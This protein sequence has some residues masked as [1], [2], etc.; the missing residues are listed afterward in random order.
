M[1]KIDIIKQLI[2]LSGDKIFSCVFIKKDNTERMMVCRRKVT[3]GVKKIIKNRSEEDLFYDVLTVFDMLK[4]SFK[5]INLKTV[6][7]L[8]VKGK[9]Y[10]F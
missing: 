2:E 1:N 7:T 6:K 10:N 3:K 5:R 4:N 8:K 9:T